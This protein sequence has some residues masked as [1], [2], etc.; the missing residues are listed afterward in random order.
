MASPALDAERPQCPASGAAR[1]PVA[2]GKK[3]EST[4]RPVPRWSQMT[5]AQL[6]DFEPEAKGTGRKQRSPRTP[7][8]WL[9][10]GAVPASMGGK[11]PFRLSRVSQPDQWGQ[12]CSH[13]LLLPFK[14]ASPPPETKA[15]HNH[16]RK[17][18]K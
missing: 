1:V 9:D 5:S 3:A 18:G 16:Y 7:V 14:K 6:W 4:E 11:K 13:H 2:G 15:V 8:L 17:F 10:S 12:P